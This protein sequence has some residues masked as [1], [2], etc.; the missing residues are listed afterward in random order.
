MSDTFQDSPD[1]TASVQQELLLPGEEALM[2]RG[3]NT[4]YT[5]NNIPD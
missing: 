1:L 5:T 2:S 3:F 4:S